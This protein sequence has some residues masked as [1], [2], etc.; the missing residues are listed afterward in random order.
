MRPGFIRVRIT[1]EETS[2]FVPFSI[3]TGDK[4]PLQTHCRANPKFDFHRYMMRSLEADFKKVV[5]IIVQS[6]YSYIYQFMYQQLLKQLVNLIILPF[7]IS[8]S[9]YLWI[10]VVVFMLLNVNGEFNLSERII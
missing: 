10:F 7:L 3:M 2:F 6:A 9:W 8:L 1:Q 4:F 5:G